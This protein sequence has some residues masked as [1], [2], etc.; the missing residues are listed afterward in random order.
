MQT[1]RHS[2]RLIP[3]VVWAAAA[4]LSGCGGSVARIAGKVTHN[5]EPVSRAEVVVESA[6]DAAQQYFGMTTEDGSLYVGYRDKSGVPPGLWK[7]RVTHFTQRDGQPLPGGEAG[8][9]L[10]ESNRA[11]ARTYVFDQELAGGKN[12]LELKLEAAAGTADGPQVDGL[13]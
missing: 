11:V 1:M 10:R 13:R 9:A 5:G 12:V 8:Q 2:R 3:V 6:T 7:I 4:V